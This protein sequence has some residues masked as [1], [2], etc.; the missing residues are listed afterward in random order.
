MNFLGEKRRRNEV[1]RAIFLR[2]H[3]DSGF[4]KS[5]NHFRCLRFRL[6]PSALL[7]VMPLY[8]CCCRF[9]FQIIISLRFYDSQELLALLIGNIK[10]DYPRNKSKFGTER[11]SELA[12]FRMTTELLSNFLKLRKTQ[13]LSTSSMPRRRMRA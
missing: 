11:G 10:I 13:N 4:Q 5:I 9:E 1:Q 2:C 3:G 8:G 12:K 6:V 7:S